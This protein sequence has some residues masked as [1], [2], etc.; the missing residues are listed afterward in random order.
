MGF[1]VCV[2]L[3]LSGSLNIVL[4]KLTRMFATEEPTV[5][6][7]GTRLGR[8]A[9]VLKVPSGRFA[10]VLCA[11]RDGRLRNVEA[12]FIPSVFLD[13]L[14]IQFPEFMLCHTALL[15]YCQGVYWPSAAT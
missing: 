7:R 3:I 1:E 8:S 13:L 11:R 14:W 2:T 9:I 10:A 4:L 5:M 12:T 6:R 15:L